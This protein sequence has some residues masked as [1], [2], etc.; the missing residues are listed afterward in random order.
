[1]AELHRVRAADRRVIGTVQADGLRW[2]ATS[3]H[4]A[5]ATAVSRWRAT[6]WLRR[7]D[8]KCRKAVARA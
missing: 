3:V 4:G 1:M 5:R 7:E 2:L 6:D 8:D